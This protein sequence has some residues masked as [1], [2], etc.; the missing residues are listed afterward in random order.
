M[1]T[2]RK[3]RVDA[4]QPQAAH[5]EQ[6]NESASGSSTPGKAADIQRMYLRDMRKR[7]ADLA[8]GLDETAQLLQHSSKSVTQK[9]LPH[10]GDE[11]EGSA[12]IFAGTDAGIFAG[13]AE[14]KGPTLMCS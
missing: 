11:T 1:T 10:Q 13:I 5:H 8:D 3:K 6:A 2:R 12:I 7:A 14:K 4:R 9:H